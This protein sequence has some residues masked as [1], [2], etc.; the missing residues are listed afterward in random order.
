MKAGH[1]RTKPIS[2]DV[3]EGVSHGRCGPQIQTDGAG[4][5]NGGSTPHL[6]GCQPAKL[7]RCGMLGKISHVEL[8]CY[9]HMRSNDNPPV[10][11]VPDTIAETW[12]GPA[13]VRPF[14][15]LPHRGWRTYAGNTAMASSA[16]C[17]VH[18]FWYHPLVAGSGLAGRVRS[19]D[20]YLRSE[21]RKST[22]SDTQT[23]WFEYPELTC[24]GRTV[25]GALPADPDY[26]WAFKIYGE[27]D[28]DGRYD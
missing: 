21:R 20:R 12:T 1:V 5:V 7:Q 4:R 16:T 18:M 15:G 24:Y 3:L 10:Q 22:I 26:P 28:V 25:P 2:V 6:D 13:P 8:R 27:K 9:Y 23:A 17:C 19:R 14:W 11:P